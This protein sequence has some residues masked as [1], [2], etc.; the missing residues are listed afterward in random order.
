MGPQVF[1]DGSRQVLKTEPARLGL[2]SARQ[3]MDSSR[4]LLQAS[5][6]QQQQVLPQRLVSAIQVCGIACPPCRW[7]RTKPCERCTLIMS[8]LC[9]PCV[10]AWLLR[11]SS[12]LQSAVMGAACNCG[13]T[14]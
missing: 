3:S 9:R 11:S 2:Q 6:M 8:S 5:D 10:N 14:L 12:I 13:Q 4:R 7:T 1:E